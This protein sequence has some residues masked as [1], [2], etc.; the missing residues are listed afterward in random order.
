MIRVR[1]EGVALQTSAYLELHL[2]LLELAT[3]PELHA[4]EP[5]A[6]A[7]VAYAKVL[8]D[9][10]TD[11]F[12]RRTSRAIAACGDERCVLAVLR[13]SGL[14]EAYRVALP[15][16]LARAW[17]VLGR[18]TDKA[19][20][21]LR[22]RLP[23]AFP[24]LALELARELLAPP[25]GAVQLDVVHA[26]ALFRGDPFAPLALEDSEPCLRGKIEDRSALLA[27]SLYQVALELEPRSALAAALGEALSKDGDAGRRRAVLLYRVA[28]AHA[29]TQILGPVVSRSSPGTL[30]HEL[31]QKQRG[32]SD[33]LRDHWSERA[34]ATFARRYAA[35]TREP[36]P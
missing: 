4:P 30:A 33:F 36:G 31:L 10:S 22:A 12:P 3:Q 23:D 19:L 16:F 13:P 15:W 7:R 26:S 5:L 9:L 28:A 11:S 29:V 35:A 17:P 6:S 21:R 25:P 32:A 1:D 8:E 24:R 18:A 2:W 34:A 27:C 14:E 20:A